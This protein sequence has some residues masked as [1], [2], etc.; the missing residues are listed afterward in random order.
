MA[1]SI[2]YDNGIDVDLDDGWA[3]RSITRDVSWAIPVPEDIDPAMK[4]KTLYVWPE[5]LIAPIN[6][7]KVALKEK[8]LDEN[9]WK[10][11]WQ[12]PEAGIYQFVGQDNVFFYVLMQGSMWIG[13]QAETNRMPKAGE[14]QLSD[15]FSCFHL[16][17]DGQKMSKSTGNFY[18]G[19]QLIGEMGYHPDQVRYFL[20]I[21]S[22]TEKLS[23]FD[24]ENFKERNK[25]LAGPLN[26]SFEKPISACHSRFDGIVPEGK[27]I[28]KTEKETQKIVQNYVRSMEKAEYSKLLF[29]IENYARIIN[30]LFTQYK[31]HDDR[32]DE[33]QRKDALYSC[34]YILKNVLIMLSPFAPQTMEKLRLSLNLPVDIYK[35]DELGKPFPANHKIGEQTEYFP[36]AE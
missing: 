1:N 5:S 28:G 20:S 27:L 35:V 32:F 21:L 2:V 13:S 9:N 23:N 14:L 4:G 17:I 3:H 8:G 16:T 7:T 26:A 19:D 24:F 36:A 31:P 11:Y 10:D 30:G 25:F 22:L 15:V 34:F 33:E 29:L 6:F 12:D 18:T